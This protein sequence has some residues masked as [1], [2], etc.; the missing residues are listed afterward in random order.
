M[1]GFGSDEGAEVFGVSCFGASLGADVLA[2]SGL[3]EETGFPL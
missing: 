2:G 3:L 1:V